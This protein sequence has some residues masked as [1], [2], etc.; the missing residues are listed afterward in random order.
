MAEETGSGLSL[1]SNPFSYEP[2]PELQAV[3]ASQQIKF[4]EETAPLA[5][6]VGIIANPQASGEDRGFAADQLKSVA[7]RSDF[8]FADFVQSVINLNVRDAIIAATGG[9]HTRVQAWDQDGKEYYKIF[10]QRITKQNPYGE[11]V[12]YE[13]L[14]FQPVNPKD[15]E[16]KVIVS[17][18]EVPL[19]QRPFYQA[20]NITAREAAQA[21]ATNWLNLQKKSAAINTAYP[22]LQDV[23]QQNKRLLPG[24]VSLSTDPKTRT[25]LAGAAEMRTGFQTQA[26]ASLEKLKEARNATEFNEAKEEFKRNSG[27][28]TLGVNWTEGKGKTDTNKNAVTN[29]DIDRIG[30]SAMSSVSATNAITATKDNLLERAQALALEGKIQNFD[31]VQTYINN[32]YKKSLLINKIEEAG[33]IGIATP[34]VPF[35]TGDSFALAYAKNE[36]D[37][38][39]AD[40]A[41]HFAETINQ[42]Q[43]K[44]GNTSPP[45]IGMLEAEIGKSSYVKD[46]KESLYRELGDFEKTYKPIAEEINKR[47]VSPELLAQPST[48]A[49]SQGPVAPKAPM[50]P[51]EPAAVVGAKPPVAKP[52]AGKQEAKKQPRSLGAIFQ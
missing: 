47:T 38:A 44:F 9:T 26:Q 39:Y 2:R 20:N 21:Q 49:T 34:N 29:A 50:L 42:R 7:N 41:R 11:L 48:A 4:A 32:E 25:L 36:S 6:A 13:D 40:L 37:A 46:R 22:E 12:G 10:N 31:A 24:L 51:A 16:G 1:K 8:R 15:I 23:I 17:Q 28:V 3:N 43:A 33:G 18:Q 27:G 45:G 19:T 5:K 35:K 30:R 14:K 52:A